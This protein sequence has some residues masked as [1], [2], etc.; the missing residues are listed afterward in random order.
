MLSITEQT[1][2]MKQPGSP[3]A[4]GFALLIGTA[5]AQGSLK[6]TVYAIHDWIS[7]PMDGKTTRSTAKQGGRG[8]VGWPR[9]WRPGVLSLYL[10]PIPTRLPQILGFTPS[11]PHQTSLRLTLTTSQKTMASFRRDRGAIKTSGFYKIARN[12]GITTR[13]LVFTRIAPLQYLQ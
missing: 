3:A 5:L 11:T 7:Y 1:V 8:G 12:Y 10:S 6:A 9:R 13:R 2:T 4:L